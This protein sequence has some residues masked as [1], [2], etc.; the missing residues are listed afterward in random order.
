MATELDRLI[1][2]IE[3][4]LAQFSREFRRAEQITD[5]SSQRMQGAL[6]RAD[7]ATGQLTRGIFNLRN[8]LAV[9]LGAAALQRALR[10]FG[11]FDQGLIGVGKTTDLAGSQLEALGLDIQ[12]LARR[13]PEATT[14]LLSIAQSAGQLGVQGSANIL[15]FTEVIGQ[16][17]GATNLQGEQAASTL[18]RLINITGESVGNV[19]RLGSAIVDLGNNFAA[20][21][22]EIAD[23]ALNVARGTAPFGV[24]LQDILGIS[25]ALRAVGVEAEAGGSTILRAFQQINSALQGGGKELDALVALTGKS[26]E[27]LR[28]TFARDATQA[29]L[30]FVAAAGEV[31]ATQLPAFLEQLGL[32]GVRAAGILQALAGNTD[33][34]RRALE[35]SNR[36]W[37]QNSALGEE[38][39]RAAEGF[40]AQM[41]ITRNVLSEAAVLLGSELAPV[42]L[43]LANDFRDFVVAAKESGDLADTFRT[44][45]EAARF[46]AQNIDLI[47]TSFTALFAIRGGVKLAALL[48]NMTPLGRAATVAAAGISALALSSRDA[49]AGVGDLELNLGNMFDR[50]VQAPSRLQSAFSRLNDDINTVRQSINEFLNEQITSSTGISPET[51][52]SIINPLDTIIERGNRVSEVLRRA[53]NEAAFG[54]TPSTL[55][56]P[57]G[58]GAGFQVGPGREERELIALAAEADRAR[59]S[60]PPPSGGGGDG[61]G[62]GGVSDQDRARQSIETAIS[63]LENEARIASTVASERE[64]L[65]AIINLENIAR[66]G[67]IQLT[68]DQIAR[69]TAA[70]RV[71]QQQAREEELLNRIRETETDLDEEIRQLQDRLRLGGEESEEFRVQNRLREIRRNL[72]GQITPEIEAQVR[73]VESLRSLDEELARIRQVN[74]GTTESLTSSTLD[75]AA[76]GGQ[77][78]QTITSAFEDAI[79]NGEKL[80]DVMEGLEQDLLRLGLRIL[81]LEPIERGLRT[82]LGAF[83]T[84]SEGGPGGLEG[85]IGGGLTGLADLIGAEGPG[86]RRAFEADIQRE[87]MGGRG[88]AFIDAEGVEAIFGDL[89]GAGQALSFAFE[90]AKG[91]AQRAALGLAD[92]ATETVSETVATSSVIGGLTA[93]TGAAFEAAAALSAVAATSAAGAAGGGPDIIS[94][95]FAPGSGTPFQTGGPVSGPGGAMGDRIPAMLSDGEF[96][97]RSSMARKHGALLEAIN[98]GRLRRLAEGGFVMPQMPRVDRRPTASASPDSDFALRPIVVNIQTQSGISEIMR[99]KPQL[100]GA[101]REALDRAEKRE[102]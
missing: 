67:N 8:A 7:R 29:F 82:G 51:L 38:A 59:R 17:G 15:K 92:A 75:L 41:Q 37:E 102:S 34:V 2:R 79:V 55:R 45:G 10:E 23:V 57:G 96:V 28:E 86:T 1:V 36:A 4:D 18:A 83:Q 31:E 84:E 56:G 46:L 93:L 70:I 40:N 81:V 63:A 19:D 72:E 85:L 69:A 43:D 98:S 80:S 64:R 6:A 50:L 73:A 74:I 21:E 68:D 88:S 62:G 44:V 89:T 78:G 25:T 5:R 76:A 24:S 61:A 58:G 9:G 99:N 52:R 3:A 11:A 71:T 12:A 65:A 33:L 13:V 66:E 32:D 90:D 16:L 42:I 94:S 95:V 30:D 39:R 49:S 47:A 60:R 87:L 27:E 91:A 26:A 22:A 77:F 101:M 53:Q 97:V 100:S 48:A 14:T 20:T 35:T 54:G